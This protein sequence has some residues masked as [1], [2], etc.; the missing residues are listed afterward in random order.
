[1]R[2]SLP[3]WWT[4]REPSGPGSPPRPGS[5]SRGPVGTAQ[6]PVRTSH[7]RASPGCARPLGFRQ[8]PRAPLPSP[9]RPRT[10]LFDPLDLIVAGPFELPDDVCE[11]AEADPDSQLNLAVFIEQGHPA[12]ALQVWAAA[13]DAHRDV[14]LR[15]TELRL[16]L[17]AP[18]SVARRSTLL[19]FDSLGIDLAS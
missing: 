15:T 17:A 11:P 7:P 1:M 12:V 16:H 14:F 13:S 3:A 8:Q 5:I 9:S 2:S 18:D 6:A 4:K 10:P 19:L